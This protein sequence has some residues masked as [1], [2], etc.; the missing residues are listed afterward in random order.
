MQ[1][2]PRMHYHFTANRLAK[3]N[4]SWERVKRWELHR[5]LVGV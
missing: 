4:T 5:L 1:I 2:K 3:I